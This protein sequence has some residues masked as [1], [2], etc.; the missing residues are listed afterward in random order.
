MA[1]L[2]TPHPYQLDMQRH[3]IEQPRS[4]LFAGM[5]MGK[6]S[7][8]LA[9]L[10]LGYLAGEVEGRTLVVA[11]L[12][13]AQSTWPDEVAKWGFSNL[14]ISPIVGNAAQRRKALHADAN[15]FTT[16]YDNIPWLLEE[17]TN[18]KWNFATVIADESTRLKG[19]R[20]RQGTMRAKALGRVAHSRVRRWHNLTGTPAPN[21][22]QDLWGQTWM[23]DA[24]ARL[25][26]SYDAF[27]SRWF[28]PKRSGYGVEPFDHSQAEI[29]ARIHD[30]CLSLRAKDYFDLKDPIVTPVFTRLNRKNR[31]MYE[32]MERE[33]FT[34]IEGRDVEAV[35]AAA[36]TQKLLQL[37]SGA[38]YVEPE[39]EGDENPRSKQWKEVHDDKIQA[40]ESIIAE[41]SGMPVLVA[42]HFRSDLA[43]LLKHFQQG[44]ELDKNPQTIRDWNNGKIPLLFA[45]PQSAG[46]GLNL[47]D[48]GNIL[49]FFTPWWDLEQYQQILER[50]GPV[51]QMQAGHDRNVF[52]YFIICEDTMDEVVMER[53]EGKRG[54]QDLL[55][56]RLSKRKKR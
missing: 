50:I 35:N 25:G 7:S 28:R 15:I 21:G 2:F 54:L 49:V 1:K 33:F 4:A 17:L 13:V 55:M 9:A 45:H 34:Q 18:E 11:P 5:G 24:G 56:E 29:E 36:K 42:Y 14:S 37:A 40:L 26:R 38:V 22:L 47:Q 19:F 30:I 10:D 41:A 52:V 12:R 53:R 27:T 8:T 23:L 48:G 3:L 6:T 39:V 44:R 31:E 16:N 51:R 32:E 43:R 20:L 46:H